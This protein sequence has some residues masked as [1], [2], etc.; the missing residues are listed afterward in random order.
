[1]PAQL[2]A[3]PREIDSYNKIRR[4]FENA[5]NAIVTYTVP[6]YKLGHYTM[7]TS[8]TDP[9]LKAGMSIDAINASEKHKVYSARYAIRQSYMQEAYVSSEYKG[10]I[11]LCINIEAATHFDKERYPDIRELKGAETLL[12]QTSRHFLRIFQAP[13]RNILF[14]YTNQDLTLKT[15][16]KLKRLQNTLDKK[17]VENFDP[18]TEEMYTAL[19]TEDLQRFNHALASFEVSDRIK[20]AK[21]EKFKR[22]FTAKNAS[23]IRRIKKDIDQTRARITEYENDIA[24]LGVKIRE[25]SK[26]LMRLENNDDESLVLDELFN[27]LNRHRTIKNV[28]PLM[29]F[30]VIDFEAPILYYTD[31]AIKKIIKNYP[32]IKQNILNLFLEK[33]FQLYTSCSICFYPDT[34]RVGSNPKNPDE[35]EFFGHPHINRY[36]C[37]G[38]HRTEIDKAAMKSDYIG[39]IEQINQA[40][41]NINFYDSC[42]IGT[43]LNDLLIS[44][45]ANK[46]TWY[47]TTTGEM[48]TTSEAIRRSKNEE[49]KD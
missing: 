22:V 35:I 27:Y 21:L 26:E 34:F 8:I 30:I 13:D 48:V 33:R 23:R 28:T 29:D 12:V 10:C 43:M 38:S 1:M 41:M 16:Y 7:D 24:E 9:I 39:A 42:V 40:V 4:D 2:Q 19:D 47:D 3:L 31:Y 37:F 5:T 45:N 6:D 17:Y 32:E 11:G 14:V 49:N 25:Q 20:R 15:I 36:N 46:E 44:E 18:L